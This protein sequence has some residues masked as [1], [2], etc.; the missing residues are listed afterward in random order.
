MQQPVIIDSHA[1]LDYPQL[2]ADLPGV[3]ARA[4]T[5]GVRQIISIGVKLSTSNAPRGIAEAYEAVVDALK[6]VGFAGIAIGFHRE[7]CDI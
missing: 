4:E 5:A 2:A 1:H 6:G 3:L 7:R